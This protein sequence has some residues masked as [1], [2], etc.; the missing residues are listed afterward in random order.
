[1]F[2]LL[3]PGFPPSRRVVSG[4]VRRELRPA[5]FV[6]WPTSAH[7]VGARFLFWNVDFFDFIFCLF[8]VFLFWRARFSFV[9]GVSL[10]GLLAVKLV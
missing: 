7:E 4:V 3:F 1:M 2:F 8:S 9:L 6:F 5:R 10:R